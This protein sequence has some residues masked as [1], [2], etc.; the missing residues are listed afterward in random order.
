[1]ASPKLNSREIIMNIDFSHLGVLNETDI[2]IT[3]EGLSPTEIEALNQAVEFECAE[4]RDMPVNP[5]YLI[6][7]PE[8][9][10]GLKGTIER[11]TGF[12]I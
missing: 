5:N 6:T 8:L 3:E 12:K 10:S 4:Y 1:M 7:N 2:V 11:E 9:I